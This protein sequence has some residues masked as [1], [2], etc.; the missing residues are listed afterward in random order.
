[1]NEELPSTDRSLISAVL[2]KANI[3]VIWGVMY[4]CGW[5]DKASECQIS[6]TREQPEGTRAMYK[7]TQCT[8]I[9]GVALELTPA[10]TLGNLARG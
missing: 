9:M 2:Q 5:G 6:H 10:P 8:V 7:W 3:S 4:C 1:M